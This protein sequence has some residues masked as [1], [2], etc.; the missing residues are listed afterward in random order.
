MIILWNQ[1]SDS[2]IKATASSMCT[3][4]LCCCSW[5]ALNHP[6]TFAAI[7]LQQGAQSFFG[8]SGLSKTSRS[9]FEEFKLKRNPDEY[10][11]FTSLSP[12]EC[13]GICAFCKTHSVWK[14]KFGKSKT[15]P[16]IGESYMALILAFRLKTYTC[17]ARFR[18][19]A[20]W[21]SQLW[22]FSCSTVGGFLLNW[23]V[24]IL[25]VSKNGGGIR[26]STSY[27][28]IAL[29]LNFKLQNTKWYK[30]TL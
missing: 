7:S 1:C 15:M 18:W 25:S 23:T 14:S 11:G 5:P 19:M 13:T 12:F 29:Y 17:K 28:L 16:G 21:S 27:H 3:L 24:S 22:K 9:K 2:F 6:R 8:L 10:R 4:G 26:S 30:S 20:E